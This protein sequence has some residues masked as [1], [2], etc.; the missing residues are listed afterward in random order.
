[1]GRRRGESPKGRY[2]EHRTRVRVRFQ[3]VDCLG[4]V[5]YGN[6]MAYFEEARAAFGER[7][8][9]GYKDILNANLIA[10]TVHVSCD[11][12]APAKLLDELEVVVQLFRKE[13]PKL[14]FYYRIFRVSDNALLAA[15][16]SV[17]AFVDAQGNLMLT[18]PD[19][20]HNFYKRWEDQML[21]TN[22]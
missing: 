9:I 8:S 21:F 12:I 15:G 4:I 6:Y 20:L 18:V 3:E 22:E 1:M 17:Q 2:L 16:K 19:F 5:W 11:Y 7:Y 14:E 13:T 10:P